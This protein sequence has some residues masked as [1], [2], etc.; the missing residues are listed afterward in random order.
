VPTPTGHS[1]SVTVAAI[2]GNGQRCVTG[3]EDRTCRVFDL[4]SAATCHVLRLP[5]PPAAITIRESTCLVAAGDRAYVFDLVS[6]TCSP[7]ALVY[8]MMVDCVEPCFDS[9]GPYGCA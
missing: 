2:D 8:F 7:V 6:C 9:K 1:D 3:A 5:A 4:A